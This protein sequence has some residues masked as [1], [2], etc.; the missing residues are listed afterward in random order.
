ML[1]LRPAG[2]IDV[3][4]L[5]RSLAEGSLGIIRAKGFATS[6]DGEKKLVQVVGRRWETSPAAEDFEDGIVCL[7]FKETLNRAALADLA[8]V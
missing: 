1:T 4:A 8:G 3:E 2:P 6:T 5:S 7:G